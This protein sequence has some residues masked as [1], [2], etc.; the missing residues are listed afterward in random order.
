M[1]RSTS[2]A[3]LFWLA[4]AGLAQSTQTRPQQPPFKVPD[5]I[6]VRDVDIFSEGTRM[7]G[8]LYS[9]QANA[10]KKLP[11][12]V[13]AHGWGGVQASLRAEAVAFA[14]A[15][16]LSLTFDYRGWGTS[17]SRVILTGKRM[18]DPKNLHFTAEVQ[19]VREVVDPNDMTVDWLNAIAFVAGEPQCDVN[20]I[21]LWGSSLSGGLVL[22]AAERD[23]RVKAVH[24]QVP[25]MQ[26]W[27]AV[28]NAQARTVMESETTKRA[29]GELG[30]P[31]P[32]AKS[33]SL[34]G[35]P[36]LYEFANWAPAIDTDRIPNCA[37]Q[38]VVAEKDELLDNKDHGLLAYQ[39]AKGP[40]YYEV[41]PNITHYG[42]YNIPEVRAHVKDL[43]VKWFDRYVKN[44]STAK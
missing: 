17:D 26:G 4:V 36:I 8:Q 14:Q 24:S 27:W 28:A 6:Q 25:G 3:A 22:S 39:K 37:I 38:I 7:S 18:P 23:P 16:Y 1:H 44:A 11:T 33:G 5:N 34:R 13:L 15:G 29:R 42:V 43:A 10:G 20:R 2:V 30:Y 19:G 31:E 9:D 21:G 40:K 41:I 35:G 12:I 32:G